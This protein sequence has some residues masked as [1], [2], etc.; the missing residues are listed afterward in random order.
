MEG[1]EDVR[2]AV[3]EAALGTKQGLYIHFHSYNLKPQSAPPPQFYALVS[4]EDDAAR[5]WRLA[6]NPFGALINVKCLIVV[7]GLVRISRPQ[8]P[9]AF[10]QALRSDRTTAT[11]AVWKHLSS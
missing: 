2:D 10:R 11:R 4:N 3:R 9:Q 7:V 5:P 6:R 8:L 1:E